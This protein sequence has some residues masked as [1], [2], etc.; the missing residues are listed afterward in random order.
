MQNKFTHQKKKNAQQ[1]TNQNNGKYMHSQKQNLESKY[2]YLPTT[3]TI[4]VSSILRKQQLLTVHCAAELSQLRF[5]TKLC[6][7]VHT[8]KRVSAK[9]S[10][11]KGFVLRRRR[12]DEKV[13]TM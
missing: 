11:K 4:I 2:I 10:N 12:R 6:T 3:T 5:R 9:K 1:A 7:H 8:Q 13:V